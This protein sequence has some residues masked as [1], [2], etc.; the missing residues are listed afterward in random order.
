[1]NY[2]ESSINSS[3]NYQQ[4]EPPRSFELFDYVSLEEVEITMMKVIVEVMILHVVLSC[5]D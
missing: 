1:M 3:Y 4:I 2:I 5:G